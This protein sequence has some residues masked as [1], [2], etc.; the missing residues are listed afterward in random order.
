M[1]TLDKKYRDELMLALRLHDISGRRVGE[2]LAEV[3]THVAET[4]ENPAEAFGSPR[5]YA[6][7]VAA[8]LDRSTGKPS[9]VDNALGALG[10][11]AFVFFGVNFLLDGLRAGPNGVAY[12]LADSVAGILTLALILVAVALSFRAG[13]ALAASRRRSLGITAVVTFVA[14]IACTVVKDWFVA[15]AAPLFEMSA[16]VSVGLGAV[17]IAV[18]LVFLARAIRRGWVVDPR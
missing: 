9:P 7:Q 11:G 18:A 14:A 4:G 13:T 3:E 15:D 2:V 6:A 8:Q 16:W 17:L 1:M 5:E 10:T 12:T